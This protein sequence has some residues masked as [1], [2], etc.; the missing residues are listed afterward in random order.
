MGY[1]RAAALAAAET[2]FDGPVR[3]V[4]E[5]DTFDL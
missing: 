5:G 3:L 4:T 2:A 1:D